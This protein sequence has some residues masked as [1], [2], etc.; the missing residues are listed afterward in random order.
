MQQD[1]QVVRRGRPWPAL[2]AAA[3]LMGTLGGCITLPRASFTEA[4]QAAAAPPGFGH[5][6][7]DEDDPALADMLRGA[8][9]PDDQGVVNTLAISG[10]GASGA[11][12]AGLLYGWD[13]AGTRP[14]FQLVTG[15]SAGAMA[16]PLA[17]A[18]SR[19]DEPL[20]RS[21]FNGETHKLLQSRGV[22]G[23]MTP[24][25]YSKGPLERLVRTWVSDELLADIAAEHAKGRRLLVATTD[26]DTG[27]LVVWDMGAIA[28]RGGPAARELFIEVL[29]ASASIPG[30]FAPS[31]IKVQA[32]GRAFEEMHV[33]GQADAAF[34][35]IPQAMLL[36]RRS[37][38]TRGAQHLYV[39]VNGQLNTA[40]AV[41]PRGTMPIL[42]RTVEA[43]TK[44]SIRSALITTLEFCRHNGCDLAVSSVPPTLKDDAMDFA[45]AHLQSLF[46][47]GETAAESGQA[48]TNAAPAITAKPAP[49]ANQAP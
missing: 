40:F 25:L 6:R 18:G 30:V 38:D 48:W 32:G 26:L 14:Q 35:A 3:L 42:G 36:S 15:I 20:R 8:L 49:A 31:M 9:K 24:G 23:L 10:G 47:A 39:I 17:F 43:S 45:D 5:I 19:W 16:A 21:Y 27:Q 44:A 28:S 1:R 13:K 22:L 33:D 41:T 37:T 29:V 46:S 34:F 7:Y 12:G 4:E 11:Y 2:L